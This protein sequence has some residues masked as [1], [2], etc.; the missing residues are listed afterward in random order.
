M[1]DRQPRRPFFA[2][3]NYLDAHAPYQ[4]PP[5]SGYRFGKAPATDADFLFLTVVWQLVD[6]SKLSR[7]VRAMAMDAYDSCIASIDDR[8]AELFGG[9]NVAGSWTGPS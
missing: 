3:L 8:L 6:K 4:A 7:P 5:G 1:R 2:F 9:C